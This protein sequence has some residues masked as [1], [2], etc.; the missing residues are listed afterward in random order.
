MRCRE[1]ISWNCEETWDTQFQDETETLSSLS[2]TRHQYVSR[3]SW[4]WLL[5][6]WNY[7]L[8]FEWFNSFTQSLLQYTELRWWCVITNCLVFTRTYFLSVFIQVNAALFDLDTWIVGSQW[9]CAVI[10]SQTWLLPWLLQ[11][12]RLQI[13][14]N[15]AAATF[16][17]MKWSTSVTVW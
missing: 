1:L 17:Q 13:E 15:P 16:L 9:R 11:E 3:W 5:R 12:L 4:Y 8:A 6:C 7:I 14:P 2:K 10:S